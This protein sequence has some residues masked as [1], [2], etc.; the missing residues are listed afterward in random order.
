MDSIPALSI[1]DLPD[2]MLAKVFSYFHQE[3][4][5]AKSLLCTC[6][7]FKN[8]LEQLVYEYN[9]YFFFS[10]FTQQTPLSISQTEIDSLKKCQKRFWNIN[11]SS[12]M[13][14]DTFTCFKSYYQKHKIRTVGIYCNAKVCTL[15]KLYE[16]LWAVKE[17]E[18][19]H[20]HLWE[21][22]CCSTFEHSLGSSTTYNERRPVKIEFN[23]LISIF[24]AS[25]Y[26]DQ[27]IISDNFVSLLTWPKLKSFRYSDVRFR[28][29][30]V[31]RMLKYLKAVQ[32]IYI[33]EFPPIQFVTG[34]N[35][36]ETS[37]E[38]RYC[39]QGIKQIE[40]FVGERISSIKYLI[41]LER[42]S[43]IYKYNNLI[44]M[45]QATVE[46]I[47]INLDTV[48][49]LS[50]QLKFF[51][52]QK[53]VLHPGDIAENIGPISVIFPNVEEI[54]FSGSSMRV[55]LVFDSDYN[56][57]FSYLPKLKEITG[58]YRRHSN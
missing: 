49:M 31:Y 44:K 20:I 37:I 29:S 28:S 53:L 32:K 56:L 52:A 55:Q 38:M 10:E 8:V 40:E 34:F 36:S 1:F 43:L 35:F 46:E 33:M 41:V 17:V 18:S 19:L 24:I 30:S 47:E 12:E 50:R 4:D 5:E 25:E 2:E 13:S 51:S 21:A 54:S 11:L 39:N 57:M 58:V 27:R 26:R 3:S 6:H 42:E 9:N 16:I 45:V 22:D 48:K 15:A 7:R 23:S 14:P